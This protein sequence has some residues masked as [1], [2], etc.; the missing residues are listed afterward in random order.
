M[1]LS[2][3]SKV[4]KDELT[5]LITLTKAEIEERRHYNWNAI[6]IISLYYDLNDFVSLSEYMCQKD[7]KKFILHT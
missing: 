4:E 2:E 3:T 7:L 1:S 5:K 6:A